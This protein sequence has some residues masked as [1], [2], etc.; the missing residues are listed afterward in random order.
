MSSTTSGATRRRGGGFDIG[1]KPF[2]THPAV[3]DL[4]DPARRAAAAAT[5]Y[6]LDRDDAMYTHDALAKRERL[7]ANP[8]LIDAAARFAR[9]V[10][11]LDADGRVSKP[12]YFRVHAA[13]VRTLM[14]AAVPAAELERILRED[15]ASDAK[16]EEALSMEALF[17]CLFE[18]ADTWCPSIS[19]SEYLSFLETLAF[20]LTRALGGGE[21]AA[22]EGA[23]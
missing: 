10:Y 7:R 21:A 11:A 9:Q 15:W 16:G 20:K 19:A 14:G 8:G 1:D 22:A 12:E 13:I 18:L 5:P 2:K 6:W 3:L 4:F 23:S 17:D